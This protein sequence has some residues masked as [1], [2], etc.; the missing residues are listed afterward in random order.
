MSD[1]VKYAHRANILYEEFEKKY[2]DNNVDFFS[3]YENNLKD[4]GDC[5]TTFE[6]TF[7]KVLG[8]LHINSDWNFM[9]CGCGLGFPMYLASKKF[10]KVYGVEIMP[11]ILEKAKD[12]LNKMNVKN[13]EIINSD[14]TN[15][16]ENILQEINVFYMFNPFVGNVFE[17]F[18]SNVVRC[19]NSKKQNEVWLIYVNAVCEDIML[20]YAD[21][22]PL[23]FCLHDFRKI[24][25]YRYKNTE[26]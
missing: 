21:V 7:L 12:N 3:C 10:K 15:V 8:K 2:K 11:E 6:E 22:L 25:F 16:A 19:L 26:K 18:I 23:Q 9:D 17:K 1:L 20:K 13:F 24:N 4:C 5:E 14:I